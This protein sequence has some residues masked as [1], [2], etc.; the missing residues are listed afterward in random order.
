MNENQACRSQVHVIAFQCLRVKLQKWGQIGGPMPILQR[1]GLVLTLHLIAW[2]GNRQST[3][4][5]LWVIRPTQRTAK[6]FQFPH[7][8]STPNIHSTILLYWMGKMT[9]ARSDSQWYSDPTPEIHALHPFHAMT[10][11]SYPLPTLY[12]QYIILHTQHHTVAGHQYQ[13][14]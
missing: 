3:W 1:G 13:A 4:R 2:F 6:N 7:G 12:C 11:Y 10:N 9:I 8:R 5:S 14:N